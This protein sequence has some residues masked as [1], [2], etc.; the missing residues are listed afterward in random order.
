[1]TRLITDLWAY[2]KAVFAETWRGIL[3]LFDILGIVLFLY[4]KLSASLTNDESL[5]KTTGG[6]IFFLSFSL[7]NFSLYRKL[8]DN[9]SYQADIRLKILNKYFS[10]SYGGRQPGFRREAP[11]NSGGFNKQGVPD[12]GSLWVDIMSENIGQE[13]GKL[14]WELDKT[15][16]KLPPLFASDDASITETN[17][18]VRVAGRTPIGGHCIFDVPFAERDPHAFAQALKSLIESN[19]KYQIVLRYRTVRVGGESSL[20]ELPIKGDFQDF[21][22]A[23]L[24]HWEDSGHKDLAEVARIT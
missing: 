18:P 20:H 15:K 6:L 8:T 19:Q 13:E 14:V 10:H 5:V 4:P 12:W 11:R 17:L 3:T 16:T 9:I 1:M 7:A 21:Y 22:Q 23:V 2:G 24:K